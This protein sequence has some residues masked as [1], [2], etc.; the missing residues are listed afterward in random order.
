MSNGRPESDAERRYTLSITDEDRRRSFETEDKRW[1]RDQQ[2]RDWLKLALL[3]AISLA[4]HLVVF[5]L[6]P[7]LR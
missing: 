2:I 4:Y 1:A 6:E 5:F 7:G 3:I